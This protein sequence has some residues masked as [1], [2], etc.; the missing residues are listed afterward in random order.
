[1]R[2][3]R[4]GAH[5]A[6]PGRLRQDR[7]GPRRRRLRH[8]RRPARDRRR[9]HRARRSPSSTLP[10][11]RRARSPAS[12]TTS[13]TGRSPAG[14]V[15]VLDEISQTSTRD[16]HD[17]LAA[18][19]ACPGGQLWVLGDPQQAPSVKAG[20]I[21]AEI[22]ARADA[23]TIPA[24]RLTVNR[25]QVDPDDRHA[26]HILRCGGAHESQQLRRDHGWEHTAATPE[27]TRRAMADAVT[28]DILA[29]GR[30]VHDRAGRVPRPGR[31]PHRPHP[32]PAHRRRHPRR[33]LDHR[34]RMDHRS[35]L[36]GRRPDAA[37]H[38]PRR[39]PL[40]ARQRH[41]RHH[42]RQSTTTVCSSVP[43]GANPYDSQQASSKAVG[44]TDHRT[45][46]TPGHAPSTA[47]R[48]APGTTPTCSAPP[49]ST[50]TAATPPNPAPS[51]PPTPGTPP[52]CRPSTSAAASPTTPTPN[53]KSPSPSPVSRTRPWP[54]ST[55]RGPSTPN[56]VS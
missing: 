6:R 13:A 17:V 24:A 10:A 31:G 12:A 43:T 47:P 27:D 56:C 26:L 49:P 25:R 45:C 11:C 32:P 33:D 18:V 30:R 44:R 4:I 20:G 54:P 22:A 39:P 55:T 42:R 36:P 38:P 48:A 9:D 28:A 29:S 52:P 51:N 37:P 19:D 16:A 15:V 23:E 1:M 41:R 35:P 40:P 53:D 50:P 14:T 21:A 46:P 34:S 8:R 2:S 7:D 5:G 3:G